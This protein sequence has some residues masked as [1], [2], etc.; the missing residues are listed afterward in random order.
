MNS[1]GSGSGGLGRL[2]ARRVRQFRVAVAHGGWRTALYWAVFGTLR[3]NRL[4]GL[5]R[6]LDG[7]V[8]APLREDVSFALLTAR[9]LEGWRRRHADAPSQFFQDLVDGVETCAAVFLKGD[10]AGLIWV[11]DFQHPSRL[12]NLGPL[13]VELNQGIILRQYREAGLFRDLLAFACRALQERG[14]RRALAM[15]HEDN[16]RSLRAFRA[17]GFRDVGS[18][19]HFLVY[20]PKLHRGT[21]AWGTAA[22][23]PGS[24]RPA[25]P[26]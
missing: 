17:V 2:A 7:T 14:V 12:F 21:A 22:G 5:A 10:I 15:V 20:R 19:V 9:E 13:E 24:P 8:A 18:V 26:A 1:N 25:R 3:R 6:E 23:P 16:W 11:Y 4:F